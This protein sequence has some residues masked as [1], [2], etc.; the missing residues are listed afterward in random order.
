MFKHNYIV[1][2]SIKLEE[3]LLIENFSRVIHKFLSLDIKY[4]KLLFICYYL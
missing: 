1:N 2:F 4:Y 3:K